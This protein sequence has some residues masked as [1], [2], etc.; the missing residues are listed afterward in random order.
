[1]TQIWNSGQG[2]VDILNKICVLATLVLELKAIQSNRQNF[3]KSAM[4]IIEA[5]F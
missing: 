2:L 5:N 4:M 1:M 3:F